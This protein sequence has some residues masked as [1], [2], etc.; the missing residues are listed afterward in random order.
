MEKKSA[1]SLFYHLLKGNFFSEKIWCATDIKAKFLLR[2]L[3][4]PSITLRHLQNIIEIPAMQKAVSIR[5]MLPTKVHRPYLSATL[6]A[7]ERA[8]AIRSHYLFVQQLANPFLKQALLSQDDYCL[9][10]FSG[11]NGESFSLICS[12]S[13]YDKEGEATLRIRFN[14]MVLASLTFSV[15][16]SQD[17]LTIMIGGLQGKGR[18]QTRELT[19]DA[20]KACFGLF[21]KRLLL[22]CLL[23]IARLTGITRILAVGDE[24]HVYQNL[25]YSYRKN[26]VRFSS[27]SEFWLSINADRNAQG[28]Y[29]LPLAIT[30]KTLDELPSKKRAQYQRRYQL[31]DDIHAQVRQNL[32]HTASSDTTASPRQPDSQFNR[33]VD[34]NGTM[35]MSHPHQ[36]EEG[37][38]QPCQVAVP[39]A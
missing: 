18:E 23:A 22:E 26:K 37:H 31:L 19:K 2:S 7:D 32:E 17:Q 33:S 6:R 35:K 20:S 12:N 14:D 5:P 27:Y 38:R 3:L 1:L 9:A 16:R 25:R 28:L 11:K 39:P 4:M 15:I 36:R 30:R 10:C 29:Q 24:N 34:N 8:E 13:R 21:P